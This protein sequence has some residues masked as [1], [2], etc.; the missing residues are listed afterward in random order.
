MTAAGM[1]SEAV[2]KQLLEQSSQIYELES[3]LQQYTA[4]EKLGR[5]VAHEVK[6]V[7]PLV[8]KIALSNMVEVQTD[9]AAAK[10]YVVAVLGCSKPL[11]RED[12]VRIENWLKVR[13]KTDSLRVITTH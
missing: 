10:H 1:M 9:S 8:H 7:C 12:R 6:I 13:T 5:E 2:S 11:P 4:Y 3:Q